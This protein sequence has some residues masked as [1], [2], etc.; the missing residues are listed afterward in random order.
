MR[1]KIMITGLYFLGLCLTVYGLFAFSLPGWASSG[2]CT[3]PSGNYPTIQSAVN[4]SSCDVIQVNPQTY[5]E[6]VL[7]NRSVTINGA[8]PETTIVDGQL[9]HR[10]F[11]VSAGTTVTITGLTMTNGQGGI[12]N[13]GN[14]HLENVVIAENY[15]HAG[16]GVFNYQGVVTMISTTVVQNETQGLGERLA[17]GVY[18]DGY[19]YIEHCF[20]C[21]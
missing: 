4:D 15:T 9:Q 13:Q 18:N 1:S 8:D 16:A 6:N 21:K 2:G 12:F 11:R 20:D 7:V 19:M 17:G 3:V 10:V 14:L 5:N